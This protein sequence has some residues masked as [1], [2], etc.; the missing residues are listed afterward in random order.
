M[1]FH[2]TEY[3]H[4]YCGD[5]VWIANGQISSILDRGI[6]PRHFSNFSV[7]DDSVNIDG[8]SQDLVC[9]LIL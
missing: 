1:D 9:A 8:F 6:R 2:Q 3:L 5:L 7:L 4:Q